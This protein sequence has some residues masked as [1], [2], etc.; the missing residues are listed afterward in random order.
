MLKHSIIPGRQGWFSH[1]GPSYDVV[2]GT[3]MRLARNLEDVPFAETLT[4]EDRL[5]LRRR[6]EHVFE[7]LP[8]EFLC[9]DGDAVRAELRAFYRA[10]GVLD[11]AETGAFSILAPD[12]RMVVQV[13]GADHLLLSALSGGWEPTEAL[14][15][16]RSLDQT[17]E[18]ELAYAV[19]L[20]LGYLSPRIEAA[21]TGL[22]AEALL[23]LPALFQA[24]DAERS[25]ASVT[26][27][28]HD[29][30]AVVPYGSHSH[31]N[32]GLVTLRCAARFPEQEDETVALLEESVERLVHYEREARQ[33]LQRDHL[34][35]FSDAV[36]R[37]LGT[38]AHARTLVR[39]E[40][41]EQ[42]ALVRM[43]AACG[44]VDRPDSATA[45]EIL[46]AVEDS[47]VNVLGTD[48]ESNMDIR[49]AELVRQLLKDRDAR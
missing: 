37:A 31:R 9:L 20:R 4:P 43:G 18:K 10:R 36:H 25:V 33:V 48:G 35:E 49:R 21:G 2:I 3:V 24:A 40:A 46:F 17:L 15:R 41:V 32:N 14:E 34:V 44:L 8:E 29:R 45:T 16:V 28:A 23:F 27:D 6:T 39:D 30:V 12:E 22:T 38:L 1:G 13:G 11:A 26:G 7:R 5:T 19:S 42:A 47:A